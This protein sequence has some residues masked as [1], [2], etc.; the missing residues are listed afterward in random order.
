MAKKQPKTKKR[1]R[2]RGQH[3]VVADLFLALSLCHN[4][5]PVVADEPEESEDEQ[6]PQAEQPQ[7]QI[8]EKPKKGENRV[9]QASSPDEIAL[10]KF[11]E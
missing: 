6:E 5:T 10:V 7:Q 9:F 4:V 2:K 11:A 1:G 3:R 8:E